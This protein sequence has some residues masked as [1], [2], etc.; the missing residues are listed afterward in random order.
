M[1]S[2][3]SC[4]WSACEP[5]SCL[6]ETEGNRGAKGDAGIRKSPPEEPG[7]RAMDL[8]TSIRV[9]NPSADLCMCVCVG[10]SWKRCRRKR[11]CCRSCR[12]CRSQLKEPFSGH[13]T[14]GW[15]LVQ[16][17]RRTNPPLVRVRLRLFT[18]FSGSELKVSFH[19][20]HLEGAW[21]ST[22]SLMS[23]YWREL[24]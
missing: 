20:N 15:T 9:W 13:H 2:V 22:D 4:D 8:Q 1:K 24:N 5:L 16:G 12:S 3:R 10:F 23:K 6:P 14:L 18:C 17:G 21:P 11:C 7:D 19:L